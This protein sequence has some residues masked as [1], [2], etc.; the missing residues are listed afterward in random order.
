MRAGATGIAAALMLTSGCRHDSCM[1]LQ[2][3]DQVQTTQPDT[4]SN[5]LSHIEASLDRIEAR[6]RA[7][8]NGVML[9]TGQLGTEGMNIGVVRVTS[10]NDVTSEINWASGQ[11]GIPS[12]NIYAQALMESGNLNATSI[13]N[14]NIF[15]IGGNVNFKRFRTLHDNTVEYVSILKDHGVVGI[16]DFDTFVDRLG[17]SGY[18]GGESSASYNS[19]IRGNVALLYEKGIW[20][21]AYLSR[22][23]GNG[24]DGQ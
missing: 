18:Y 8:P 6:Q 20:A 1:T 15:G 9:R 16:T 3:T 23:I 12:S 21:R 11:L 2:R 4:V 19:K 13:D 10:L 22:N 17:Q 7:Q 14:N 5:T 24:S